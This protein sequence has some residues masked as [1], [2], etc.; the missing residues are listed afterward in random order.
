MSDCTTLTG[1]VA[2]RPRHTVTAEGLAITSFR[3]ARVAGSRPVRG[4]E[5][6]RAGLPHPGRRRGLTP[7]R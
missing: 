1:I 2:T 3:H 6:Q 5:R 4:G 7:K